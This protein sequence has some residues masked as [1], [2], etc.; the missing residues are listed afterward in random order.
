MAAVEALLVL[1]FVAAGAVIV[2]SFLWN[3][4]ARIRREL[5]NAPRV[6]IGELAEGRAGRLVGKVGDGQTLQAP[7]TGRSC[8]FYEATV[9]QY[10]SNGKSG[11]WKEVAREV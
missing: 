6:A 9:E 5:R 1:G 11:T 2:A 10:R 4:K 3:E 7:L 8:V